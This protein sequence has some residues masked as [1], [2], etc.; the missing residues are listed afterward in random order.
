MLINTLCLIANPCD[1]EYDDMA[2]LCCH[3]DNGD[4]FSLGRFPD[5]DQVEIRIGDDK[6]LEV[7]SLKITLETARLLIE[8]EP[9]D[10]ARL[11]G[12][13]HYEIHYDSQVSDLAEIDQTLRIILSNNVG[14]YVSQIS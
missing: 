13:G 5:E 8:L 4:L 7:S 6:S 14:T 9:A 2:M 12:H 1:D 11:E 3:G 10:A